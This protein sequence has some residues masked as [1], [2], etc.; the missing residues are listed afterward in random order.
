VEV[1]VPPEERMIDAWL[2]EAEGPLGETEAAMLTLPV[3]PPRLVRVIVD[4]PEAPGVN[5][6]PLGLAET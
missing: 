5:A 4:V 6:R 2:N 3:N 1:P